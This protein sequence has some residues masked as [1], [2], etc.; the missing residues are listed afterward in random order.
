MIFAPW[1]RALRRRHRVDSVRR[2]PH[3]ADSVRLRARRPL[4]VA[5]VR[6]LLPVASV[7][8]P[9]LAVVGSVLRLLPA[10][11]VSVLRLR[12]VVV[13]SVLRL[14]RRPRPV[15]SARRPLPVDSVPRLQ[16]RVA[17][18]RR[19]LLVVRRSSVRPLARRPPRRVGSVLRPPRRPVVSVL[20]PPLPRRSLRPRTCRRLPPIS[21]AT[22]TACA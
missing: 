13:A 3:P 2:L 1:A 21:A 14:A 18:A 16:L 7:R 8:L 5:S 10:V 9:R 4:P 12:L 19:R 22:A 15:D 6:L 11:V 20:R 17:S